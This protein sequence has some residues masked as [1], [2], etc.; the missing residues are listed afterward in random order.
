MLDAT[1][2]TQPLVDPVRLNVF[3]GEVARKQDERERQLAEARRRQGELN[4]AEAENFLKVNALRPGVVALPSGL[5]YKV[6]AQGAG[7]PARPDSTV[8]ARYVGRFISG[9]EF[10]RSQPGEPF[11]FSLRGGVI[12]GWLEAFRLMREGDRWELYVPPH[13]A[14]GEEGSPPVIPSNSLLIF[15]VELVRLVP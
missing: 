11:E 1:T 7:R 9:E 12:D 13:L 8:Q 15:E 5:Q 2:N 3:A 10:D 4:L 14:Y 6:L